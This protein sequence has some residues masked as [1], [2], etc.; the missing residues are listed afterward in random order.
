MQEGHQAGIRRDF[1]DRRRM[2][3][4]SSPTATKAAV[5]AIRTSASWTGERA[6]V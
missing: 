2:I 6:W 4:F 3:H 5:E 1:W